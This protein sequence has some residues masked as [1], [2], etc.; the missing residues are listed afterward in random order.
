MEAS[1]IY[2][3]IIMLST[4]TIIIIVIQTFTQDHWNV[5]SYSFRDCRNDAPTG[6]S[7]RIR[8]IEVSSCAHA[9]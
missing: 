2:F 7:S 3:T 5:I 4:I 9:Q 1:I 8:N 6:I